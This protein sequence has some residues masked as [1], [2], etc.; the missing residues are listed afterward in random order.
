MP[1]FNCDA[2]DTNKQT[3]GLFL[4]SSSGS[5]LFRPGASWLPGPLI[6]PQPPSSGCCWRLLTS[7][8]VGSQVVFSERESL[9]GMASPS[10]SG[11]FSHSSLHLAFPQIPLALRE[12][13]FHFSFH[14]SQD[15]IRPCLVSPPECSLLLKLLSW[16]NEGVA[17]NAAFCLEKCLEVPGTATNL[18][19]TD[20]VRILLRVTT[21]SAQRASVQDNAAIAL[22]KLCAADA[23][24]VFF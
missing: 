8:L 6:I 17:G 1:Y 12:L 10:P 18:L 9:I 16:P 3:R 21:G 13:T 11:E 4:E 14:S 15:L 22:G 2:S 5:V 20:V 23:R 19:D 7:L 24:R